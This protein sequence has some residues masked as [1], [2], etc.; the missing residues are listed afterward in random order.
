MTKDLF[1][2]QLYKLD[3]NSIPEWALKGINEK[4]L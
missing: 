1:L 2:V 4:N 3:S